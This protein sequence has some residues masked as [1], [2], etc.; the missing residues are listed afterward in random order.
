M[1]DA[2]ITKRLIIS[3]RVQGVYFRDSMRQQARQLGVTGW[4]RNRSDGTV[5]AMVHGKP[6]A[7][8]RIIEWA[9]HGPDTARV[10]DVYIEAAQGQFDN[11]DLLFTA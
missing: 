7:V 4:V 1:S 8:E 10:T 2:L 9:H 6:D 11:F 3:G 5:E